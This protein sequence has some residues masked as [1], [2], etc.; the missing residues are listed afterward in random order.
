MT[1]LVKLRNDAIINMIGH[2]AGRL[3]LRVTI[4]SLVFNMLNEDF[5]D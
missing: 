3:G 2:E 4:M 5:E 1:I